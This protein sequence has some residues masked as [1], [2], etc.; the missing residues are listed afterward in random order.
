M[1]QSIEML[2]QMTVERLLQKGN[3]LVS[4]AVAFDRDVVV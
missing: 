4:D 1:P 2:D 3:D